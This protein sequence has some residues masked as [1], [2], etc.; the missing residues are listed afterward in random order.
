MPH[1][2]S[3]H[4]TCDCTKMAAS[5][6]VAVRCEGSERKRKNAGEMTVTQEDVSLICPKSGRVFFFSFSFFEVGSSEGH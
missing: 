2:G 4:Q 1:F 5:S 3:D 6:A